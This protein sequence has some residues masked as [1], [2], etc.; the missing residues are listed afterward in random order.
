MSTVL[1]GSIGIF[2]LENDLKIF[3]NWNP[4]LTVCC[5]MSGSSLSESELFFL[6]GRCLFL[7]QTG[8]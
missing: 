2:I 6:F 8:C 1:A 7:R 3:L 4:S 5:V